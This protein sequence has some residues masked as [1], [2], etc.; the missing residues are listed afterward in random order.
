MTSNTKVLTALSGNDKGHKKEGILHK[1]E[2]PELEDEEIRDKAE[3]KANFGG[4]KEHPIINPGMKHGSKSQHH[5]GSGG[6]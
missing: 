3:I 6:R 5:G 2:K 1:K 4:E